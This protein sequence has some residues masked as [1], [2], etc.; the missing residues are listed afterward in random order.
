MYFPT[1]NLHCMQVRKF[2]LF[3]HFFIFLLDDKDFERYDTTIGIPTN[4]EDGYY[5]LMLAMLVGNGLS[6]YFSCGKLHITGGNPDFNC[7]SNEPPILYDCFKSRAGRELKVSNLY[8]GI[9][10]S[11]SFHSLFYKVC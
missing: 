6:P 7:Q 5:V 11:F 1:E 10:K 3:N 8:E 2:V 4:L 9:I